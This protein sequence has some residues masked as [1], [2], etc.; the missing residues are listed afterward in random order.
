LSEPARLDPELFSRFVEAFPVPKSVAEMRA[1]LDN[2]SAMLNAGLPPATALHE[3]V[4]IRE[5][6]GHGVH[7]DVVVPPGPGP[8]PVLVYLHGG[9]WVSGSPLTHRKLAHRF[10]EAGFLVVNVDYR[11]APEH[12]FPAG[13]EDCVSAVRWAAREAERFGGDPSRL[14]IGGDSAGGN[15]SAATAIA[16]ARDRSAPRIGAALLLYGVFDFGTIGDGLGMDERVAEIGRRMLE[17]MVGSY[18]GAEPSPSLL[19]DPR[20][21]PLH[22]A[23]HLPPCCVV[24]GG[25]DPLVGQARR[26]AAALADAG[27]PHEHVVVDG[28]PHGFAQMEFF[29]QARQSIDR[30]VEFLRKHLRAD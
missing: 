9:G 11:L 25:A 27:V 29:P 30:M 1:L 13:F 5:V 15:L 22:A 14:A 24:V 10:A 12:P 4:R 20:V 8:H 26:L 3:R 19:R 28:M 21:S 6:E 2:F 16:L 17:L 7:A 18:L 23:E